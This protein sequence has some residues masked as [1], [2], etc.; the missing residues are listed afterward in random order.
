MPFEIASM[1]VSAV[2]PLENACRIRNRPSGSI[3]SCVQCSITPV[4]TG[5]RA[6]QEAHKTDDQ[7]QEHHAEEEIGRHGENAPA[8]LDAAQIDH[9]QQAR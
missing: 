9:R 1:P 5:Q 3:T 7:R 2:Q 8:F 4:T 6:G